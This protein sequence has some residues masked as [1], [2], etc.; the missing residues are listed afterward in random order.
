MNLIK[1]D[2]EFKFHSNKT[3]YCING[4][5]LIPFISLVKG[6]DIEGS[7]TIGVQVMGATGS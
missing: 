6:K 7:M 5:A 4:K 2:T 1:N 3:K